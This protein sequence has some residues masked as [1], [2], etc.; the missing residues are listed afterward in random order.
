MIA[1]IDF[2]DTCATLGFATARV[3]DESSLNEA[4]TAIA[5]RTK[6]LLIDLRLDPD[7]IEM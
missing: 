6:P 7:K 3:T 5:D 4:C 2:A 1:R